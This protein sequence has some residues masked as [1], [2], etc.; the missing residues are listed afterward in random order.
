MTKRTR[1]I[2]FAIVIALLTLMYFFSMIVGGGV[3]LATIFNISPWAGAL[4]WI[5]IQLAMIPLFIWVE[6]N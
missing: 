1:K 3:I 2:I 4:I 5:G 6:G